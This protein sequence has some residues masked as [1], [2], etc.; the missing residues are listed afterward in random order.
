MTVNRSQPRILM[1]FSLKTEITIDLPRD[2]DWFDG[3]IPPLIQYPEAAGFVREGSRYVKTP[4]EY[5]S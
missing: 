2:S 4:A 1:N 3:Y 5:T